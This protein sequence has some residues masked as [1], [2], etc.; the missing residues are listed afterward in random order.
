MVGMIMSQSEHLS[1]IAR[2]K[3]SIGQQ[4]N[5]VKSAQEAPGRLLQ[6]SALRVRE[7]YGAETT[8]L[9]QEVV[10]SGQVVRL[11]IDVTKIDGGH[12]LMKGCSFTNKKGSRANPC[13]SH[14]LRQGALYLYSLISN[15]EMLRLQEST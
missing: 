15:C 11:F 6:N 8:G 3:S 14:A 1:H 9:L 10:A 7:W 5:I 12:R 2:K 4:T 13:S